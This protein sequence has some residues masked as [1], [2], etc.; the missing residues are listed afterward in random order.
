MKADVV[1]TNQT[2]HWKFIGNFEK[3]MEINNKK[4][5]IISMQRLISLYSTSAFK[6]SKISALV[7][8]FLPVQ[9]PTLRGN[10]PPPE[11]EAGC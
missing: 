9:S 1:L 8:D 5:L 7:P 3:M 2:L 4:K 11:E 6:E 10:S